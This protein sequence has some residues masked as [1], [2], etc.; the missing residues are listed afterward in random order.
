MFNPWGH[1]SKAGLSKHQELLQS[2]TAA[3]NGKD[4]RVCERPVGPDDQ[5]LHRSGICFIADEWH[6][7]GRYTYQTRD[8]AAEKMKAFGGL[9]L[10]QVSENEWVL[11]G[12]R[13]RVKK[14][15][16][17]QSAPFLL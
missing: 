4:W 17:C 3:H 9:S 1:I 10:R 11:H 15:G 16:D 8:E 12:M 2:Y 14:D 5:P 7:I 6:T 13:Y